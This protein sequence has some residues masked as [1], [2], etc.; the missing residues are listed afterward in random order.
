MLLARNLNHH[1]F[2]ITY[3]KIINLCA[4]LGFLLNTFFWL[5]KN[6]SLRYV[7]FESLSK[8]FRDFVADYNELCITRESSLLY[9][10]Q[11]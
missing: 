8:R 11:M 1:Q 7:L 9:T 3:S 10:P 4:E 5:I 2:P 6:L